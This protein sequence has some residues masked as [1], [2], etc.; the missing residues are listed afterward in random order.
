LSYPPIQNMQKIAIQIY[1]SEVI[2]LYL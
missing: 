2:E 1:K